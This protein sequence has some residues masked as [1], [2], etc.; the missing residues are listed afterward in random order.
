[1]DD[2]LRMAA[3]FLESL[4]TGPNSEGYPGIAHD[5]EKMRE[6]LAYIARLP[7]DYPV[8]AITDRAKRA[9]PSPTATLERIPEDK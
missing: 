6:T 3:A 8:S 1:M 9:L 7:S 2:D 5:F 4:P